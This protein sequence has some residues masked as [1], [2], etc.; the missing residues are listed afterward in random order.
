MVREDSSEEVVFELD[1][2]RC[3]GF[4]WEKETRA[5]GTGKSGIQGPRVKSPGWGGWRSPE[6]LVCRA[7]V[8]SWRAEL[9]CRAAGE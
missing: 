2:E 3:T 1:F 9:V 4:D 8:Q 6:G 5:F 7:G